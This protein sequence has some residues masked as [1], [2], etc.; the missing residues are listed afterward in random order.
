[1]K[2]VELKSEYTC[3]S[4]RVADYLDGELRSE[5]MFEFDLHLA[6]CQK[7]SNELNSQKRFH[8]ALD[9]AL[10]DEKHLELPKDFIRTIVVRAESNVQGLRAKDERMTALFL[11][12]SL[13]LMI[14]VSVSDGFRSVYLMFANFFAQV[15]EIFEL[16]WHLLGDLGVGLDIVLRTV[17]NEFFSKSY[18]IATAFTLILV[19]S[20]FA[21]SRLLIRYHRA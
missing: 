14:A 8:C 18:S 6:Q 21:L 17:A 3:S 20:F 7:C 10:D 5:E 11:C 9:F 19:V 4:D 2:Q 16:T 12:S 1:M 13:F 15:K